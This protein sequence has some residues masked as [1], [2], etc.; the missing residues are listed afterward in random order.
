MPDPTL[1]FIAL[2]LQGHLRGDH[3]FE[4]C[5]SFP[6]GIQ[7]WPPGAPDSDAAD[8]HRVQDP[9]AGIIAGI[10]KNVQ[11]DFSEG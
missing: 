7:F 2:D 3:F 10:R 11:R 1:H 8:S 5:G 4:E 9:I 6:D